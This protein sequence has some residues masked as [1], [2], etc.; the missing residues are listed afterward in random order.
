MHQRHHFPDR[1][2]VKQRALVERLLHEL[3]SG[4]ALWLVGEML[5]NGD[6][7][8][9]APFTDVYWLCSNYHLS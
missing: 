6:L 9:I 2:P 3:S 7:D 1:V 8:F 4:G 5:V